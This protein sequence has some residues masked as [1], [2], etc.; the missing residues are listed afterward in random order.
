MKTSNQDTFISDKVFNFCEVLTLLPT[1]E[2][3]SFED[4]IKHNKMID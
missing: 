3:T 2:Y 4:C 1:S